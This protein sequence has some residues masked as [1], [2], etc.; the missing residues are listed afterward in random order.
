MDRQVPDGIIE[1][2]GEYYYAEYPPATMVR[3]LGM[4][5][6]PPLSPEEEKAKTQMKNELF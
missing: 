1:S 2:N 3:D 6:R 4:G 5:D